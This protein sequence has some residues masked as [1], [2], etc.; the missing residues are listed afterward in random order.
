MQKESIYIAG[1]VTGDPDYEAKFAKAEARL[2]EVYGGNIVNPVKE[3]QKEFIFPEKIAWDTLMISC[4]K[5]L[6]GC[7]HI[8]MLPDYYKSIGACIELEWARKIGLGIIYEETRKP[9]A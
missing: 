2:R 7:T 4:L 6:S 3:L 1:Q 8:Y 9:A 5:R